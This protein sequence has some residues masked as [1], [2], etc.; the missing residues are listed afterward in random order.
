[1]Y[2][3][4]SLYNSLYRYYS[5]YVIWSILYGITFFERVIFVMINAR[6]Q[7]KLFDKNELCN[8]V[9]AKSVILYVLNIYSLHTFYIIR[10]SSLIH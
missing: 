7:K 9:D 1:M 2:Y 10:P 3:T 6:F 4:Q 5:D 8:S